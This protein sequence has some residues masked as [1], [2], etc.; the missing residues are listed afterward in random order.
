MLYFVGGNRYPIHSLPNANFAHSHTVL[1]TNKDAAIV[2][3]RRFFDDHHDDDHDNGEE[4]HE[5]DFGH[6]EDDSNGG[7]NEDVPFSEVGD[8][9]NFGDHG[10]FESDSDD[11][12]PPPVTGEQRGQTAEGHRNDE[13]PLVTNPRVAHDEVNPEQYGQHLDE[14][15]THFLPMNK[16]EASLG[17]HLSLIHI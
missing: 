5:G 13:A 1:K 11:Q 7:N 17:Y 12:E 4:H 2:G 14:V 9:H 10:G 16:H 15:M 6:Q 3:S 8:L